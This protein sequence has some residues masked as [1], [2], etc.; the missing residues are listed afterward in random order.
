METAVRPAEILTCL[1]TCSVTQLLAP[2]NSTLCSTSLTDDAGR[3]QKDGST[4]DA[5]DHAGLPEGEHENG[6]D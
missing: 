1:I 4:E 2:T 6:N 5:E 3:E